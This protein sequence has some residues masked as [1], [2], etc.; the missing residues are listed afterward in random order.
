MKM[1]GVSNTR[2]DK[3]QRYMCSYK[4]KETKMLR[5]L[6]TC[7]TQPGDRGTGQSRSCS[8]PGS[9]KMFTGTARTNLLTQLVPIGRSFPLQGFAISL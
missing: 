5:F 7:A 3:G 6:R 4:C 2:S 1:L 9:W 8:C